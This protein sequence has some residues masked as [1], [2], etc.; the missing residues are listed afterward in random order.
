MKKVVILLSAICVALLVTLMTRS[1][2]AAALLESAGKETLAVSNQLSEATIKLDHQERMN[3][4][5]KS[6]FAERDTALANLSNRAAQVRTTLVTTRTELEAARAE[7]P[8]AIARGNAFAAERDGFSNRVNEV[9][10]VLRDQE[11][12]VREAR[13][14]TVAVQSELAAMSQRL[15][16]AE[17]KQQE[18]VTRFAD[19]AVLRQQLASLQRLE[20]AAQR[21]RTNGPPDYR[22][23]ARLAPDGSV[24][25]E[26]PPRKSVTK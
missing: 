9:E 5:L 25:L 10:A 26:P 4:V 2:R 12:Q 11:R 13:E 6:Q 16:S 15:A 7:I 18:M 23:A 21:P 20:A 14:H 8:P 1:Q 24:S 17:L 3:A 19:P 22:Y